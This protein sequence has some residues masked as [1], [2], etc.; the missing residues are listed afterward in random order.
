MSLSRAKKHIYAQEHQLY[1]FIIILQGDYS[2]NAC[3]DNKID[4]KQ[5]Y[6]AAF[7]FALLFISLS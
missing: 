1:Y 5:I 3:I 6:N 7:G 2:T 4:G